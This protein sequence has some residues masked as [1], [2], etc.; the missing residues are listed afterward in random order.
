MNRIEI[1]QAAKQ[2]LVLFNKAIKFYKQPGE[3]NQ[4]HISSFVSL[5]PQQHGN[6]MTNSYVIAT[7][8]TITSTAPATRNDN[9]LFR[10]LT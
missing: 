1:L 2:Q 3:L 10:D 8:E 5:L 4:M 7:T 6:A 9:I